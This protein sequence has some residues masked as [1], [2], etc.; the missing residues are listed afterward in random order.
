MALSAEAQA[1]LKKFRDY[2]DNERLERDVN[3]EKVK[4]VMKREEQRAKDTLFNAAKTIRAERNFQE[5]FGNAEYERQLERS[6]RERADRRE[7]RAIQEY[8]QRASIRIPDPTTEQVVSF[9]EQRQQEINIRVQ[10]EEDTQTF[11]E[12][13]QE[14]TE[15]QQADI[16]SKIN[17]YDQ[18]LQQLQPHTA[19]IPALRQKVTETKAA[20]DQILADK[21][22]AWDELQARQ[23]PG[24]SYRFKAA[25]R[26]RFQAAWSPRVRRAYDA[27]QAAQRELSQFTR[28][29]GVVLEITQ[30]LNALAL[31]ERLTPQQVIEIDNLLK[32][33]S[34]ANDDLIKKTGDFFKDD[35]WAASKAMAAALQ[36]KRNAI[37]EAIPPPA[38]RPGSVFDSEGNIV[39]PE[40]IG[41]AVT[42][43]DAALAG[44]FG[45]L[46]AALNPSPEQ[47]EEMYLENLKA[48]MKAAEKFQAQ[49]GKLQANEGL[50]GRMMEQI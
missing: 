12:L 32:R 4:A 6:G 26:R 11:F 40:V 35:I 50:Q 33:I 17:A 7:E 16:E 37:A 2:A 30:K 1:I 15:E 39:V 9:I 21:Q 47:L 3:P 43:L 22:A 25:Q 44:V 19:D 48:Q 42:G 24:G 20:Y 34:L 31:E 10:R 27:Y 5:T 13:Q 18:Q 8:Q 46:A 29:H 14:I 49:R 41:D 38:S 45:P 28:S 23:T 36:A